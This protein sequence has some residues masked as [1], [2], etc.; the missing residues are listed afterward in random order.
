[1]A[2]ALDTTNE[3][4]KLLK[5]SPKRDKLFEQMKQELAPNTRGFCVLCATRWT[6][7]A[8]SLQDVIDYWLSRCELWDECLTQNNWR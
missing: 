8:N 3:I 2:D 5:Y 6:V 4:S 1:M 7:R